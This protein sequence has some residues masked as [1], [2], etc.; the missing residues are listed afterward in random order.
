M[1]ISSIRGGTCCRQQ[2]V[3]RSN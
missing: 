3:R 2:C 1:P